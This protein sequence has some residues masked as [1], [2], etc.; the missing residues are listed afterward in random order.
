MTPVSLASTTGRSAGSTGFHGNRLALYT[1]ETGFLA[2]SFFLHSRGILFP[3][4]MAGSGADKTRI[5]LVISLVH[6]Y[7]QVW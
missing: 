2:S 6:F 1:S 3:V 5:S 4:W 7:W